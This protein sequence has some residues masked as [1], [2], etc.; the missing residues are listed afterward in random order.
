[1]KAAAATGRLFE[2]HVDALDLGVGLD[3]GQ[4]CCPAG[5]CPLLP[6]HQRG[7]RDRLMRVSARRAWRGCPAPNG[8]RY[9]PGHPPDADGRHYAAF[10][11]DPCFRI[12]THGAIRNITLYPH[13]VGR[14]KI[15][16]GHRK[17]HN[18][19]DVDRTREVNGERNGN[20]RTTTTISTSARRQQPA[21]FRAIARSGSISSCTAARP[22]H[23]SCA[24]WYC[25][26]GSAVLAR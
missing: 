3:L 16:K 24:A 1:M 19:H 4:V 11:A 8:G 13:L 21:A 20:R 17:P 12:S 23:C 26:C 10:A 6:G 2:S 25:R 7:D 9:R 14:K 18:E 5:A 22:A 15:K